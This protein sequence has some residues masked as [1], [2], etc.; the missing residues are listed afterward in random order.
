[1]CL[2][3]HHWLAKRLSEEGISF[4][5]TSNAFLKCG[6]FGRLQEVAD[7]LTA[8]DLLA[9]GQK[10]LITFTPFFNARER[11]DAGCRHRLFFSQVEYCENLIFHRRAALDAL[12]ERLLDANR[13]IG[14][15]DKITVIFGRKVS[16]RYRG[17]LQ[18]ES[19]TCTFPI[20]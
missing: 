12:G 15:P 20:R 14:R 18:T 17:K 4:E 19:R 6:N 3:Q 1:M 9:C 16:S 8:K 13:M 5:K 11:K 2:N 10:W 7:S